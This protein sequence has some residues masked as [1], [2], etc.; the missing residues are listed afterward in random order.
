MIQSILL[1][2]CWVCG[3]RFRDSIPVGPA[4]REDHHIIPRAAGGADGPTVTLCEAHHQT[5]HKI[6]LRLTSRKPYFDLLANETEEQ[7]KKLYWLATRVHNAF[8]AVKN[9]PNKKAIAM[10]TLDRR[11][12]EM[13]SM[14]AKVYPQLRSREDIL[15]FALEALFAKHFSTVVNK[16]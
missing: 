3:V 11:Q 5:L 8:A 12:Q 14:L 10:V 6:A 16:S 4:V 15:N 1:D 7:R 13:V 2:H 9:D